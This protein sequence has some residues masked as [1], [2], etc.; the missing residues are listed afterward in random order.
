MIDFA[1]VDVFTCE[2]SVVIFAFKSIITQHYVIFTFVNIDT[3]IGSKGV[4]TFKTRRTRVIDALVNV[5]TVEEY[6]K[7]YTFESFFT[8]PIDFAFVNIDTII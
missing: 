2:T 1:F 8:N 7:I 3:F 5:V 6:R 4:D